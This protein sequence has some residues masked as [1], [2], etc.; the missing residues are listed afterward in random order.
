MKQKESTGYTYILTFLNIYFSYQWTCVIVFVSC[1]YI[2]RNKAKIIVLSFHFF[3]MNCLSISFDILV[4]LN[5]AATIKHCS[6]ILSYTFVHLCFNTKV[7]VRSHMCDLF[8]QLT[9]QRTLL[10]VLVCIKI[11]IILQT[12]SRGECPQAPAHSLLTLLYYASRCAFDCPNLRI[13]MSN[14]CVICYQEVE[15]L[16]R[17]S[18][19]LSLILCVR[20]DL[21]TYL[22]LVGGDIRW[23]KRTHRNSS[24]TTIVICYVTKPITLNY[25]VIV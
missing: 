5:I 13:K 17:P 11:T 20:T 6:I 25:C 8:V 18:L 10:N 19:L 15:P 4:V 14:I 3:T 24:F 23:K 1:Q 16:E 7:P 22:I 2:L 21:N 9:S 12:A